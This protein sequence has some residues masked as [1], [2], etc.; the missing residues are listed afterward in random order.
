MPT[1][2]VLKYTIVSII[3][4]ASKTRWNYFYDNQ[5]AK[6]MCSLKKKVRNEI[7]NIFSKNVC[8]EKNQRQQFPD[9]ILNCVEIEIRHFI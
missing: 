8:M 2:C 4:D 9:D 5:M 7:G 3:F 6:T 1:Q